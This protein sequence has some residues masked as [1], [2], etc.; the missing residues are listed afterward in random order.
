M[1]KTKRTHLASLACASLLALGCSRHQLPSEVVE[2]SLLF[3]SRDLQESSKEELY[4]ELLDADFILLGETHDNP[5]HHI[6]QAEVIEWLSEK[7]RVL[8]VGFEQLNTKEEELLRKYRK[9]HP[10]KWNGLPTLLEWNKKGWPDWWMYKPV[11]LAALRNI[12]QI[13]GLNFT[14]EQLHEVRR[15]SLKP[16]SA[17]ERKKL[18]LNKGLAPDLEQ[19]LRAELKAA[20]SFPISETSMQQ[21]IN[22]QTALDAFMAVRMFQSMNNTV[23]Q[24]VFIVGSGHAR[25]DR[26]VP[27]YLNLLSPNSKVV[28]VIL[29]EKGRPKPAK[30]TFDWLWRTPY[31]NN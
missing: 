12:Q 10:G 28:A 3:R 11:F 2:S 17:P 13:I 16:I 24:A 30:K 14:K 31:R 5:D 9:A 7:K 15:G 21:M 6:L 26:G 8:S 4:R 19:E 23:D 1:L 18:K 25:K 22:V 29:N 27:Y 20:H